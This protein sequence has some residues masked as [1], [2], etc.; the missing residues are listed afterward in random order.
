MRKTIYANLHSYLHCRRG[1]RPEHHKDASGGLIRAI[2][3]SLDELKLT[4]KTAKGGRKVTKIGQ[5]AMDLVAGQV[6][7][8]EA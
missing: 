8:G 2:L 4:E 6:A 3:I 7:R 1:A 5:Q